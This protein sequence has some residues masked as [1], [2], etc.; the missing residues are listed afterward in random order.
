M[1]TVYFNNSL[2]EDLPCARRYS[3]KAIKGAVIPRDPNLKRG[4]IF[5]KYAEIVTNTSNAFDLALVSPPKIAAGME[6]NDRTLLV[7]QVLTA[8]DKGFIKTDAAREFFFE[9]DETDLLEPELQSNVKLLR[10]GTIDQMSYDIAEDFVNL[11]DHKT[12]KSYINAEF[13][14]TYKLKSQPLF[15]ITAIQELARRNS[16]E[17]LKVLGENGM[18]AARAGR[19]RWRY[20]FHSIVTYKSQPTQYQIFHDDELAAFLRMLAEKRNLA[21]FYHLNPHLA[22]TKD[23]IMSNHCYFCKFKQICA[24]Q[25]PAKEQDAIEK[26]RFGFAPYDPKHKSDE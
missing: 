1:I 5:H 14:L 16:P 8:R 22:D 6:Q 2:L 26:W 4:S 15:Y 9:L 12:T 20:I 19:I 10:V 13:E 24:L 18:I 7:N 17:L 11:E 21:A 3:L 23:G 25:D